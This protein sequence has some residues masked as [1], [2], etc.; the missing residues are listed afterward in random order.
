MR[1]EF[2]AGHVQSMCRGLEALVFP[3]TSPV[4]LILSP[5]ILSLF[6]NSL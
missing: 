1:G 2:Q 6:E 5:E 4:V 3:G